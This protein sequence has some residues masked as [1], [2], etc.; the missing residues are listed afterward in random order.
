MSVKKLQSVK[1]IIEFVK[2]PV[3]AILA[4]VLLICFVISHT[5]VP[6]ES[7]MPTILPGDHFIVNRLPYYYRNPRRGEIVVF[8]K[9]DDYLI[10]RVIGLPGDE[11]DIIDDQVYV[12]GEALDETAYLVDEME[13]YK[14]TGTNVT[15]P[16]IVPEHA[17]FVMGDNRKN[18]SD[19]R[20]FG[21][22]SESM[23][24]AEARLRIWPI[25]KW[26]IVK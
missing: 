6:T 1:R 18:S 20:V 17:Y 3:L 23:I 8:V 9:E 11:I 7:M 5:H 21:A 22:V 26:G 16:Y 2:E 19:S 10:K 4:A 24:V 25:N 12:N 14:F 13:T 15:Y